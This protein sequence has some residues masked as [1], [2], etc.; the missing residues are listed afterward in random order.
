[1]HGKTAVA[2]GIKC[3]MVISWEQ[4][5]RSE[6]SSPSPNHVEWKWRRS[7]SQRKNMGSTTRKNNRYWIGKNNK[8]PHF[9]EEEIE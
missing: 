7:G 8:C 3:W 4:T 2:K 1:M 5:V 9:M 6:I